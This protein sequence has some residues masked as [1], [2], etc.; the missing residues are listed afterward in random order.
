MADCEC[1]VEAARTSE[2]RRI[3][4][5]ALALNVT[6]FVVEGIAGLM[7]QSAGLLADAL[8]M[9]SDASTYAVSLLAIGRAHAFKRRAA[10]FSGVVL[11]LLGAGIL[12]ETARRGFVGSEPDGGIMLAVAVL[13]LGVNATVLRL[14]RRYRQGE[15]HLRASW[16]FTR[17][18]VIANLGVIAAGL[19]VM[20]TAS[21]WPDLIIGAAIGI[22]VLKEATEI[23]REARSDADTHSTLD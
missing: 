12:L 23:M 1:E 6:M 16:I 20:A 15:V 18:D 4:R 19:L 7:A 8:D 9:L 21:R 3:L 2:Q 5:V 22:Y 17:A 14:L 11:A 13:A 10:L